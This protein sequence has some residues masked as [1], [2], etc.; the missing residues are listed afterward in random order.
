MTYFEKDF[1]RMETDPDFR[2]QYFWQC[3]NKAI[4]RSHKQRAKG[5]LKN[6]R[7]EAAFGRFILQNI[8]KLVAISGCGED[9][10]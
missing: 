2:R 6:A 8:D 5:N 1:E 4:L 9:V 3:G 10:D 7:I